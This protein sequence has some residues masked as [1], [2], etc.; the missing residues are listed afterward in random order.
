MS[1]IS[2]DLLQRIADG[3]AQRDAQREQPFDVIAEVKA[4]GFGAGRLD[5]D[6]GGGGATFVETLD[7]AIQL[8]AADPNVAHCGGR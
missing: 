5:A 3:A 7:T 8:G 2:P 1:T 4:T 6:Y